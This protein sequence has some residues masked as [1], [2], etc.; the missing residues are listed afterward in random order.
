[1][2]LSGCNELVD[3]DPGPDHHPSHVLSPQ[4]EHKAGVHDDLKQ[5]VGARDIV[6]SNPLS[7]GVLARVT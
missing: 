2:A 6:E 5:V 3:G 1:M 7:Y 4:D